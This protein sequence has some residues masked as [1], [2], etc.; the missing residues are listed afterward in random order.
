MSMLC[1]RNWIEGNYARF[2]PKP[3]KAKFSWTWNICNVRVLTNV[4]YLFMI[5]LEFI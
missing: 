2:Q 3:V 5:Y 4:V 1:A